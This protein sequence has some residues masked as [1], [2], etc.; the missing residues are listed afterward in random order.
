[1]PEKMLNIWEEQELG[2]SLQES[3]PGAQGSCDTDQAMTGTKSQQP[4][5]TSAGQAEQGGDT[6]RSYQQPNKHQAK[7]RLISLV[8]GQSRESKQ[9]FRNSQV[10][11][12]MELL[13]SCFGSDQLK[14]AVLVPRI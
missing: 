10:W 2:W 7:A 1:M 8:Q 4:H 14:H 11:A 12:E 13:G 6:N 9:Q 3:Q 5:C